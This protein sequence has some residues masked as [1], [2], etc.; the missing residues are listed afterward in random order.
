MKLITSSVFDTMTIL[1]DAFIYYLFTFNVIK[2]IM[3]PNNTALSITSIRAHIL[4][5]DLVGPS[6]DAA[7]F[8]PRVDLVAGAQHAGGCR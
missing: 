2:Y 5:G 6:N 3:L 4:V 7:L 1:I 8:P